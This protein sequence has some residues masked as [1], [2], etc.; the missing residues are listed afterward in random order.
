MS[1]HRDPRVNRETAE[2]LLGGVPGGPESL[3]RVLAAAAAPAAPHELAGEQVVLAEFRAARLHPISP[4]RRPSM[5]KTTVAKLLAAKLLTAT[6]VATAATG[7]VAFAAATNSLPEPVQGAAHNVFN[8][9][10]PRHHGK[11]DP[12]PGRGN[13]PGA[14]SS[15]APNGTPS[16]SLRG[17]CTAFQAGATSNDGKALTNPAFTALVTA[18]GGTSKLAAYCTTLIGA[19]SAHPTGKPSTHP[20]GKPSTHPTGKPT[21]VPTAGHPTG[22]PTSAPAGP[23]S[24]HPSRP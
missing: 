24:T 22:Q 8:A 18:A 16:P 3:S 5:L 14:K 2:N 11:P 21:T 6:A 19:P 4:P 15:D 10:A 7:G 9:P 13:Q 12:L 20:S 17:L 23:P 1:T